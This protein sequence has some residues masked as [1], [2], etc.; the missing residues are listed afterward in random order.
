MNPLTASAVTEKLSALETAEF[1]EERARRADVGTFD[2]RNRA[3]GEPPRAG[4]QMPKGLNRR[5][6]KLRIRYC[7][8]EIANSGTLRNSTCCHEPPR[9]REMDENLQ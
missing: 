4:D 2:R 7:V 8:S 6:T 3:G 9:W 5:A 1:F